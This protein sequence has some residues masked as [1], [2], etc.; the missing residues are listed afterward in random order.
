MRFKPIK[1]FNA[2][3]TQEYFEPTISWAFRV[4]LALN[5][6]LIV[7]S[8]WK[9]FSF[10]VTWAAFGGYM[11]SLTDYRGLHYKKIVIQSLETVLIFISAM[12]GMYVA[13]SMVLSLLCMFFVGMFAALVRNWSDYGSSIGVAVGFFFLFGLSFPAPFQESLLSGLYL[14]AGAGWAIIITLFSFPFRPLNPVKRS[15]AKIWKANTELLDVIIEE[16]S[17]K[18]NLAGEITKKEM[19]VRSSINESMDLFARREKEAKVKAQHYDI[20]ID[21]RRSSALYSAALISLYE[22]L[23]SIHKSTFQNIKDSTLYKTLSAFAQ[24]SARLSILIYTSRPED[25]TLAK[26][27]IKRC[28]IAIELFKEAIKDLNTNPAEQR[29]LKHFTDTLDKAYNDMQVTIALIE[30]KLNLKK[31][32]YFESYKLS[33]TN[34]MAGVDKWIFLDFLKSLV[35][36]NSDQF[37]YALRVSIG[38]CIAVFIFKFFHIDHG[39]WIALTMIIVIQPYYGATRKKGTERIIGTLAGVILGGL[40]MLLPLPHEAFV[41]LLVFVSFFVAYFLRNN[42]KVGV[43]FVTI[44]MVVLMQISQRGSLELIGWRIISTLVGAVMAVIAGYA[45]WPVWEKKRFPPLMKDALL[46]TKNYL[47]QVIRYYQKDLAANENWF[48]NRRLAEAAN[49]LV[50]SSVER[51][52]EEPKHIQDKVDIYFA[53]VGVNVRMTREITSV[54]LSIHETK[55]LI[56]VKSLSEFYGETE[57]IIDQIITYFSGEEIQVQHLDFAALKK[58]LDSHEFQ[59]TEQLQFIKMEFEKIIF[60]LEA[61]AKLLPVRKAIS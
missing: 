5:V 45:F 17:S 16:L 6:P 18:E 14:L 61:I 38:L 11:I 54:A 53:M 60:E 47:R 49:N 32:D 9:G 1:Q 35:N 27:R 41:I 21:L 40:I 58:S 10:E 55:N 22:E 7:L 25:L 33:Y 43:F 44:M 48:L 28:E 52:Y 15:V 50:F 51:M 20:M 2:I 24:A 13:D 12:L 57:K 46:Q 59:S 23:S 29:A 56:T 26:V 34:F 39:Y 37:K 8:L 36:F 42:Y 4:V 19:A 31:S 30:T 3:L